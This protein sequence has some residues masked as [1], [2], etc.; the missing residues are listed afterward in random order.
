MP[1]DWSLPSS[2]ADPGAAGGGLGVA[3]PAPSRVR[4]L[5]PLSGPLLLLL[6]SRPRYPRGM[7]LILIS[8]LKASVD[9]TAKSFIRLLVKPCLLRSACVGR[10]GFG[11]PPVRLDHFLL[12][13]QGLLSSY[14]LSEQLVSLLLCVTCKSAERAALC[15][16]IDKLANQE[17]HDARN[18]L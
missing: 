13:F 4:L 7:A 6:S 2:S 1:S 18:L 10:P 8:H 5:S 17:K 9:K 12:G 15:Q 16:V 3:C 14:S 11:G